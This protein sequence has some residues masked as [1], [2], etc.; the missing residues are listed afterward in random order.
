M[1]S[2]SITF[3]RILAICFIL[4]G[5]TVAWFVL[6]GSLQYRTM[7]KRSVL[8]SGVADAWG[9]PLR[10]EQ[11]V[12]W[13]ASPSG[14]GGKKV[15]Q[16]EA[17][18]VE[19]KLDYEALRK[20]L[21]WYRTYEARFNAEYEIPNPA[22]IAQM[23]YVNFKLPSDRATY[24]DVAFAIE[25]KAAE[26][27]EPKDGI[28]SDAVLVPAGKSVKLKVAYR[29]RGVDRWDYVLPENAKLRGFHLKMATNFAEIDFPAGTGSPTN[30]EQRADGGWELEWSYSDVIGAQSIGMDMPKVLNA[31][32][33]ATRISFF[34]PV[35]LV[36][37][38]AV[39][40]I[41]GTVRNINLHPMNYFFLAAGCFAFQLLFAY[42]VDILPIHA[43]FILSA[44]V[45]MVLVSGYLHAVGGRALSSFAVPAQFAYMV[46]FSY[47][48]FFDG[49]S[50]LTI[51][52]GA[53]A[54]LAILM[55]ST[56][57]VDWSQKFSRQPKLP[58]PVET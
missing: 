36:F 5:A 17:S 20:G 27:A 32:P 49:L 14:N 34:A 29:A 30:R 2:N 38:F 16:A 12:I 9:P 10:Q 22:P 44:I 53:I 42:L 26:K 46:L 19:V 40:L 50:G 57:K 3:L 58:N 7:D 33:V 23:V 43:A 31:G 6:A 39:L 15:L 25:G 48:F 51:T 11:P 13:V 56:A 28:L 37:F 55:V 4:A 52:L 21:F 41:L 8:D 47:S 1:K 18:D 54:T 24:F 45:S 35:S